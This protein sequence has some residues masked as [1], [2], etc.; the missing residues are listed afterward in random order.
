[1]KKTISALLSVVF[2]CGVAFGGEVVSEKQVKELE[3]MIEDAGIYVETAK[4]GVVLSGYVDASYSYNMNG[5]GTDSGVNGTPGTIRTHM[6][7]VDSNDFNVNQIKL[8]LEKALPEENTWA[9]GFRVDLMFGE[10][11][12]YIADND[13]GLGSEELAVEQA[14]VMFRVPVGNGLDF[15][16]GKFVS[17][18]GY[19]AIETPANLN[20]SRGYLF[21][22][23]VPW[24][25]TGFLMSYKF[26]DTVDVKLGL[27]NGWNNSDSDFL[28]G[29]EGLENIGDEIA[30]FLGGD[31]DADAINA[32]LGA[33]V[34]GDDAPADFAK[35]ITAQIAIHAPGG[36]A[37]L[38]NSFMYSFEGENVPGLRNALAHQYSLPVI[39]DVGLAG[40]VVADVD[41]DDGDLFLA[42]PPSGSENSGIFVWNMWGQWRPLAFK[43]KLLLA[44]DV[45]LGKAFDN[46]H[47][48]YIDASLADG[49]FEVWDGGENTATW[50][51]AAL[52]A[53]YQVT[54]TFSLAARGE[55]FHDSDGTARLRDA[56]VA[57]VPAYISTS[58]G[59]VNDFIDDLLD[60]DGDSID[61]HGLF[62]SNT[63]VWSFTLTAGLELWE[64]L[65]ARVE[66]RLD[67][68]SS[69]GGENTFEIEAEDLG[70]DVDRDVIKLTEDNA[71]FNNKSTQHTFI[72]DFS[73]SF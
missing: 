54:D 42:L 37:D 35:A 43:D 55:Y 59:D 29:G 20:V 36:N 19:E 61:A 56:A 28:D 11:A 50:W 21:T 72:V 41:L 68:I 24:T 15:K 51:G 14:Y 27:V 13:L 57:G 69:D 16:F 53:K 31:A 32:V 64:N 33:G 12:K 58:D 26:N 25:H 60:N 44:F 23:G 62:V 30:D 65:L 18:L 10:D 17:L 71:F 45:V 9:A 48:Q 2:G 52:Y 40:G 73:Y 6:F 46:V 3:K 5:G 8:A 22:Y 34:G 39:G 70:I 67:I 1:M 66:Y 63:D 7:D 49:D 38:V 47:R 4:K